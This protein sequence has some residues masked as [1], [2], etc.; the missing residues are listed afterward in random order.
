[1]SHGEHR[2]KWSTQ[3]PVPLTG[4][5]CFN[6]FHSQFIEFIGSLVQLAN[7]LAFP[8]VLSRTS[9]N[10]GMRYQQRALHDARQKYPRGLRWRI[11]LV[12]WENLLCYCRCL[13][14]LSFINQ[15][16]PPADSS[17]KRWHAL[18]FPRSPH[19]KNQPSFAST[20]E[21]TFQVPNRLHFGQN[22]ENVVRK[23]EHNRFPV[24]VLM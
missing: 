1:M 12:T 19:R 8:P 15:I 7:Q 11:A 22:A 21:P 5:R 20:W 23:P 10:P 2:Q 6:R 24:P 16:P 14:D 17:P 18:W 4:T 3:T 9:R 13:S